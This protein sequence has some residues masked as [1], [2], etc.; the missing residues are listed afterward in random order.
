MGEIREEELD[1][2]ETENSLAVRGR[3]TSK[4][5]KRIVPSTTTEFGKRT[6][7]DNWKRLRGE[8]KIR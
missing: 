3:S 7:K 1:P 6:A 2:D 8:M 5:Y 4:K